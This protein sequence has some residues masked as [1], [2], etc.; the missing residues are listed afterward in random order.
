[1]D[2]ALTRWVISISVSKSLGTV[3]L[4]AARQGSVAMPDIELRSPAA[5]GSSADL[6]VRPGPLWLSLLA[7]YSSH[8][9]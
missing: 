9:I 1:M 7:S 6:Y 4:Q 5:V 8:A 3:F 2:V